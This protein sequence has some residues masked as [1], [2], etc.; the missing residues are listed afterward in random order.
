MVDILGPEVGQFGVESWLS[1]IYLPL[2]FGKGIKA[3]F[4]HL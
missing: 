1:A 4:I 2:D 3:Q